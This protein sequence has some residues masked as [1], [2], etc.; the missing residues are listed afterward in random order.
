M[1]PLQRC[2][3]RL[4]V[5]LPLQHQDQLFPLQTTELLPV[6]W[7]Q[8]AQYDD[9]KGWTVIKWHFLHIWSYGQSDSCV[10]KLSDQVQ[11]NFTKTS[12]QG[13][14]NYYLWLDS[15]WSLSFL[16]RHRLC[17][18]L[19]L[20]ARLVW[21][22]DGEHGGRHWKATQYRIWHTHIT[23][24]NHRRLEITKT[25]YITTHGEIVDRMVPEIHPIQFKVIYFISYKYCYP[26]PMHG[27]A[28]VNIL[29]LGQAWINVLYLDTT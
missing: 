7:E 26:K 6:T 24:W 4:A 11:R 12:L 5:K 22:W 18:A 16:A 21:P 15:K 10:F 3:H 19:R 9:N 1:E 27:Q 17:F 28:W 2:H 13:A 29:Y 23:C 20:Q 25:L 14:A 8:M